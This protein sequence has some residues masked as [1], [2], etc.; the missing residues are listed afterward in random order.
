M[1]NR[2]I[3]TAREFKKISTDLMSEDSQNWNCIVVDLDTYIVTLS[4]NLTRKEKDLSKKREF[5]NKSDYL[6]YVNENKDYLSKNEDVLSKTEDYLF[7]KDL[8]SEEE[9]T[10]IRDSR[11]KRG[12][13]GDEPEPDIK[14]E[15]P[16]KRR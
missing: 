4:R 6:E 15:E 13:T 9:K 1:I 5:N 3:L 16:K 8:L 14:K 11:V 12:Y 2:I 7:K 10:K